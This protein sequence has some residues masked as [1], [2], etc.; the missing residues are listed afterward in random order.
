MTVTTLVWFSTWFPRDDVTHTV[1]R[2]TRGGV[3]VEGVGRETETETETETDTETEA[4]TD[5]Q[6]DRQTETE[7]DRQT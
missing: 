3:G 5:R 4:E 1:V 7:T 2:L 6:T